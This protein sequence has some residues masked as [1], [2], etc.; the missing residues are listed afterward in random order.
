MTKFII[1]G[2]VVGVLAFIGGMYSGYQSKTPAKI[3]SPREITRLFP[4]NGEMFK[5]ICDRGI[6][7]AVQPLG[8]GMYNIVK[9]KGFSND[10]SSSR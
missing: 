2:I 4:G 8:E 1:T 6:V 3:L 7:N 10:S 9:E 5:F